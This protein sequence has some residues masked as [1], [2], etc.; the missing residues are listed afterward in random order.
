MFEQT[1]KSPFL[2]DRHNPLDTK[3]FSIAFKK[4]FFSKTTL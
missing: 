3:A 2:D 4:V 1:K